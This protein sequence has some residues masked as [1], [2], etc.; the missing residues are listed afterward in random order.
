MSI[1]EKFIINNSDE[2]PQRINSYLDYLF[3]LEAD[4]LSRNETRK[5]PRFFGDEIW[6]FQRLLRKV[7]YYKN[8]KKSFIWKLPCCFN[9]FIFYRL[10]LKLGFSISPN[11]FGPGLAIIHRGTI[12]VNGA[13]RIGANC[14]IHTCVNIGA[15]SGQKEAPEIGKNVYIAPGVKIFG[16]IRIA[17]N[18]AI[19][20]NAV[21][22][23]SFLEQNITIAGV[24]AK[25]ISDN[26]S[27]RHIRN[28]GTELARKNKG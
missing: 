6:K 19:G 11:C 13:S 20:A 26:G 23:K 17:D 2:I 21:V 5:T 24:P 15:T 27:E 9:Y 12:V 1:P 7:E 22:N 18:I 14:R 28:L 8:C 10:S 25:K 4:R 16:G 3:F